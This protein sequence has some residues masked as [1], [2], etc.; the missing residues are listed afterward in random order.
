M[1]EDLMN[2][3]LPSM[4]KFPAKKSQ[5]INATHLHIVG[6]VVPSPGQI[7]WSQYF[8]ATYHNINGETE[9]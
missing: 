4:A 3:A 6:P 1:D 7:K 2:L 8:D 9:N 5:Q